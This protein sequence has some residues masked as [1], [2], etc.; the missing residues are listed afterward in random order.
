MQEKISF[1][2]KWKY[3]KLLLLTNLYSL[4]TGE[5]D[6]FKQVIEN[7]NKNGLIEF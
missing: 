7:I 5:I 3:F 2:L 1:R 4:F 6:I